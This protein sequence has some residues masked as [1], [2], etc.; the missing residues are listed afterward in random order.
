MKFLDALINLLVRHLD[1]NTAIPRGYGIAWQ[2]ALSRRLVV[3][4]IG[5]NVVGA[6]VRRGWLW[7]RY[8]GSQPINEMPAYHA[9]LLAGRRAAVSEYVNAFG[10][11]VA[12]TSNY[13][14]M[15]DIVMRQGEQEGKPV[16]PTA[17]PELWSDLQHARMRAARAVIE[18]RQRLRDMR[19][20]SNFD[21]LP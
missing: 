7:V 16:T 9:G 1:Y 5:L 2:D 6:S 17:Q 10:R 18:G 19:A 13:H 12:R 20:N 21:P 11:L 15:I 4:P 14:D 8:F 3:M